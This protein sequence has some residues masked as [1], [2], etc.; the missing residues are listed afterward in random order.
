MLQLLSEG[1]EALMMD[2]CMFLSLAG[3]F[4]G[5][6][7]SSFSMDLYDDSSGCSPLLCSVFFLMV[8]WLI[9]LLLSG[10][11]AHFF[12]LSLFYLSLL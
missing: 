12:F 6:R 7:A 1:E 3:V 9:I 10:A 2:G 5:F 11:G 4:L 8:D